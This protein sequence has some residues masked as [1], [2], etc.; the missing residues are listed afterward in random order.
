M[1][2]ARA[3]F[4]N[5]RYIVVAMQCGRGTPRHTTLGL[6]SVHPTIEQGFV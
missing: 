4:I 3:D 6:Q 1:I 2:F 5:V